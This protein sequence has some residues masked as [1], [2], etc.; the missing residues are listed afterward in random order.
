MW[1]KIS[2]S[3]DSLP[4]SLAREL[5][6]LTPEEQAR[7]LGYLSKDR[8]SLLLNEG[9]S[10]AFSD[11]LDDIEHEEID[12]PSRDELRSFLPLFPPRFKVS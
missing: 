12:E 1:K 4:S 9:A 3:D 6:S 2:L 5:D 11:I 10:A 7:V 8:E